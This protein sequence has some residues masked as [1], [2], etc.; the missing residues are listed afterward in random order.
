[1]I[2]DVEGIA[3]LQILAELA[4]RADSVHFPA[5][6]LQ[7]SQNVSSSISFYGSS[8]D[9][10]DCEQTVIA[11]PNSSSTQSEHSPKSLVSDVES[12]KRLDDITHL[13]MITPIVLPS[14]YIID[15]STLDK[16]NFEEDKWGR[17]PNDPFTKKPFTK[18]LKPIALNTIDPAPSSSKS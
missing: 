12:S 2:K 14:G 11:N 1:M 9:D 10:E 18:S 6:R 16:Y 4:N 17:A 3:D 13:P 15:K 8:N 5:E 7:R